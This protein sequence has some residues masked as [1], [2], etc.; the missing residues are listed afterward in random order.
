MRITHQH[1]SIKGGFTLLEV[2]V[3]MAII[4]IMSA[5]VLIGIDTFGKSVRVEETAGVIQDVIKKMQLETTQGDFETN[6]LHFEN[7]FLAVESG[8]MGSSLELN[9]LGL[10][11]NSCKSHEATLELKKMGEVTYLIKKDEKG[12][13]LETKTF[14]NDQT[15]CLDFSSSKETE[16][17]FETFS[18]SDHSNVIRLI[19]FNINRSDLNTPIGIVN[20]KAK[21]VL[22]SAPFG[23]KEY[24]ENQIKQETLSLTL[25]D[26]DENETIMEL[27]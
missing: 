2:M 21:S 4:G 10:G 9:Y 19:H 27:E 17:Q 22:I 26:G 11:A 15:L 6:E 14:K 25:T 1:S 5:T 20:G 23:K 16:W 18:G 13:S 24:F 7:N 12:N 8:L 3:V